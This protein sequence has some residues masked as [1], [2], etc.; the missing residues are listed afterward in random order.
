VAA[1]PR[2]ALVEPLREAGLLAAEHVSVGDAASE[3]GAQD[4][5]ENLGVAKHPCQT[6][7]QHDIAK[8][9]KRV[10]HTAQ[11]LVRERSH[12]YQL[13]FDQGVAVGKA[14]RNAGPL[15]LLRSHEHAHV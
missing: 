4:D 8:G 12:G 13:P 6:T 9:G 3:Q 11:V 14:V 2:E 5:V 10:E 1:S 7:A 15:L